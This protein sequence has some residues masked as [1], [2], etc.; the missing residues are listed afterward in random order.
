MKIAIL[1]RINKKTL[2]GL[3]V[4]VFVSAAIDGVSV[5]DNR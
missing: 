5:R 2:P 3:F 4:F 1:R